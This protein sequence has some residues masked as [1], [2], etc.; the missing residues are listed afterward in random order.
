M[1]SAWEIITGNKLNPGAALTALTPGGG[2]SFTVRNFD[3]SQKAYLEGVWGQSATAG[4]V[5]VRSSKMHD[6]VN[7][8][9]F[10]LPAA[11]I[12]DLLGDAIDTP[13]F[14]Q[15]A[16]TFEIAG[17]AAET[18]SAALMIYYDNL[19]G[20][21]D[22]MV[23]WEQVQARKDSVTTTRIGVAGPV[24]AG[25]WSPGTALSGGSGVLDANTQYAV[26]GYQMGTACNAFAI[27]GTD[28]ANLK[29]GG[30]GPTEPL[31]T[32][33]W[34]VRM[35]QALKRPHIPVINSANLANI[36]AFVALNTAAGTVQV[37]LVL[38]KLR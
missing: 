2:D 1:T 33:D 26:L 19:P 37:D 30:P 10:D 34:F 23:S 3:L 14:P 36:F 12:R 5:R 24:A 15:D 17:G 8:L 4:Q 20:P 21:T 11:Q 25:D 9:L 13:L 28:T 31:E 32:R 22:T 35:S 6:P 29:V 38:A 7:G 16:L 18:D 27:R